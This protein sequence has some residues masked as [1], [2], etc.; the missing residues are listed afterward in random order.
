MMSVGSKWVV[1]AFAFW[2]AASGLQATNPPEVGHTSPV[3]LMRGETT[4]LTFHGRHLEDTYAVLSMDGPGLT[5]GEVDAEENGQRL[6]VE[7]SVAEDCAIGEHRCR[8]LSERGWSYVQTLW[9][10]AGTRLEEAE[11]QQATLSKLPVVIEG[12]AGILI[13]WI[14]AGAKAD[15][16]EVAQPTHIEITPNR[17]LLQGEGRRVP[18][19]VRAHYN[20]GTDRDVTHLAA[21]TSSNGE[22]AGVDEAGAVTSGKRGEAFLMARFHTLT[23]GAEVIVIPENLRELPPQPENDHPID[24]LIADKLERLRMQPSEVC[25][26]PTFLRRVYLDLVGRLPTVEE[27]EQFLADNSTTKRED[28]VQQ[29]VEDPD[30][31][32]LWVMKW[33]ELLQIR[34]NQPTRVSNKGS[35]LYF[36]WLEKKFEQNTPMDDLV[37]ELL[38][39]EGSTFENPPAHFYQVEQDPLKLSENVAQ[40][41][42]GTR[43][44]CAQ[45]HNHPF[46]RW[47]MEDYYGWTSFFSQVGRKQGADPR[48]QIIFNR[49]GGATRHPVTKKEVPPTFLGGE[50]AEITRGEDRRQVVAEWL[51][52]PENPWFAR[53]LGNIVWAHF[54]GRGIV[55]PVDDMRLSNPPTNPEL[56]EALADRLRASDFD[57][58]DLAI[59]ICTSDAYQRVTQANPSN[60]RDEGNFARASIRRLRAEVLLDV[61]AE[62][63]GTPT[64]LRGLPLGERAIRIADGAIN[65]Y[66][67]TTFGRATRQT[68][69]SCEVQLEP[70]LSQALHLINGPVAHD[71]IRKGRRIPAALEAGETPEVIVTDL[72]RQALCRPPTEIEL[73]HL[74][75]DLPEE[76]EAQVAYL[77]DV[78]W[79]LL[80]SKEFVFNH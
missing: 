28:W 2:M 74:L 51:T 61:L 72:Y 79:A 26:D 30:F 41:F 12:A 56:L 53:N 45:C 67:L 54:F 43:L 80:N 57:L 47:T 1:T 36:Q 23:E 5:F 20:D 7:V 38:T 75:G 10:A 8:P 69:C 63:T 42:L 27:Q 9:V 33:A 58:R 13:D 35:H 48:E 14:A 22:V 39:A 24:Q 66:F 40:V 15:P 37:V 34:T 71:H 64:K 32:S 19:R 31:A 4:T 52:A 73:T 21:F 65:D 55:E 16:E 50:Q 49:G 78:F 60:V 11:V 76:K 25:D 18:L 62:L 29:L 17:L 46:D 6:R 70:N 77:E 44:Q 59:W 3:G 68:V